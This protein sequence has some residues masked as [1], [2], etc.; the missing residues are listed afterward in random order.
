MHWY[1]IQYDTMRYNT[2]QYTIQYMWRHEYFKSSKNSF[3]ITFTTLMCSC[4]S[5]KYL[6]TVHRTQLSK[7]FCHDRESF[8]KVFFLFFGHCTSLSPKTS[9]Y[10]LYLLFFNQYMFVFC[11]KI[12]KS[13]KYSCPDFPR[14]GLGQGHQYPV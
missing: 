10:K 5:L 3:I 8:K 4:T 6:H 13:A 14:T 11:A 7:K 1:T 2:I 12:E 9:F